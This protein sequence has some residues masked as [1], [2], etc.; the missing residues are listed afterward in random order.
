MNEKQTKITKLLWDFQSLR[1]EHLLRLCNCTRNDIDVLIVNKVIC[2]DK[3][4]NIVYHKLKQI[5]NR[6]VVAFDVVMEYLER[7]PEILKSKRYPVNVTLKTKYLKYDIIAIKESEIESLYENVDVLSD[8]DKIIIIIETNNYIR[9]KINTR[10]ECL[11]CT[12]LPVK[13]VDKL[14]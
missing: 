4:T 8:A 1:E 2:R 3:K 14:N 13:I 9:R 6:N 12:C 5:N 11:I 10:R 7:N